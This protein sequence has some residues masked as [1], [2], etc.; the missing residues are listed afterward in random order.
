MNPSSIDISALLEADSNF[1][2]TFAVNLFVGKEP[3][4]PDNCVTIFDIPGD[5]PVLT[6]TGKGGGDYY[7]PSVQVRVRNNDYL[8]G[9]GLIHD[10]QKYL[11]G[12][13]G[14]IED[15]TEYLL[16]QSVDSP[17]LLDWD[18]NDRVRFIATFS[19]YRK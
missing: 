5:A 15:S 1:E 17:F 8:T 7:R 13:N 2:L 4:F 11:H 18:E 19:I 6:L 12:I 16:I 14:V 3:A 10:I 9:W